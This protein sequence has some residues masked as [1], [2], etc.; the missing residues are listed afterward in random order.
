[1]GGSLLVT[2]LRPLLVEIPRNCADAH[3]GGVLHDIFRNSLTQQSAEHASAKEPAHTTG[4]F[5]AY[6]RGRITG[7]AG[8]GLQSATEGIA[9]QDIEY[10][11][12]D[13][14]SFTW[15]NFNKIYHVRIALRKRLKE[16]VRFLIPT[17]AIDISKKV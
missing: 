12:G 7:F 5:L 11:H 10:G 2:A 8:K 3:E 16:I 15:D 13:L 6:G 17:L 9:S 14:H 1:L 4:G